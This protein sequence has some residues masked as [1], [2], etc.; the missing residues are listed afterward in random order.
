M[1][2]INKTFYFVN[3]AVEKVPMKTKKT[4]ESLNKFEMKDVWSYDANEKLARAALQ[5]GKIFQPNT[6]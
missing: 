6:A 1:S 5:H 2:Y 3:N 4:N